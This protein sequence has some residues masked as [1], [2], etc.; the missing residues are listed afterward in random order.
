MILPVALL[1]AAFPLP[2]PP[3]QDLARAILKELIEIDTTPHARSTTAAAE[4][5]ARRARA[6][7][8]R[9]RPHP[10]PDRRRGER[11]GER[12][13]LAAR[14]PP[15]PRRRGVRPQ[16]GGRRRAPQGAPAGQRRAGEREGVLQLPPGG[17]E[18]GRSQ[19]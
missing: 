11:D 9:P 16:R 19:L 1:L 15:P 4:P 7:P 18:Q 14:P 8:P 5:A 2:P 17:A 13:R 12:R 6:A 10:G 3:E